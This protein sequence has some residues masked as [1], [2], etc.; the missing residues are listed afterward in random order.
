MTSWLTAHDQRF[1][2][3]LVER[4]VTSWET[5]VGTSDIGAFFVERLLDADPTT[6]EGLG[7]LRRQSPITHAHSTRT[8]TLIVHSEEDWRCPIEQAEQLFSVYR[9][10]GV[11]VTFARFPGENHELSRSGSP[12]HRVERLGLVHQFF[13]DHLGGTP[14]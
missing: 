3:A 10:N 8:P 2:A 12:R 4:A 14:F 7:S 6:P 11:D 1:R 9:T 13:A 5:M